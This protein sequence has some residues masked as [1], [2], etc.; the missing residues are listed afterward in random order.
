MTVA[1][2]EKLLAASRQPARTLLW[3]L[4]EMSDRC[5]ISAMVRIFAP[6]FL[7]LWLLPLRSHE[8]GP[9]LSLAVRVHLIQS[10]VHPRLHTSLRESDIRATFEEV[11]LIWA[12]AG[13]RFELEGVRTLKALDTTPKRWF[14]RDRNWVKAAIPA[15][16]FS[17]NAIDV[18]FVREM[19]PNGFFY[20]EPVVVC[21]NPEF[22][23]VSG[24]A[25]NIVARVT[26][27]ELGHVLFLQHRQDHTNLM[28]SGRNG[29]SL[30]N[31]EIKDARARAAQILSEWRLP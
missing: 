25:K 16:T 7:L 12:Q 28:A 31:Q 13:I 1:I 26:A 8:A 3:G 5:L 17:P 4:M 2:L 14:E 6:F 9:V 21:E 27:H 23:K 10:T 24:G 22:T 29:I 30:N 18:C 11:N 19:G 20:G 15:D